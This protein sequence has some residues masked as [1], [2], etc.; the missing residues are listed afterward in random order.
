VAWQLLFPTV[1]RTYIPF[2]LILMASCTSG[3]DD[4][5]DTEVAGQ[6]VY[7]DAATNHDGTAKDAEAPPAQDVHVS[8]VVEGTGTIPN[9]D[10]QCALDPA[11]AFQAVYSGSATLD[12]SGAYVGAMGAA[13]SSI[14][15]PSG[16]EIPELTVSLITDVTVRAELEATTENCQTYCAAE[17]RADA[18]AECGATADQAE[19][20]ANAEATAEASCTTTC[21]TES[22][23]IVAEISVGASAVGELD[24]E[25]LQA[26]A[27]GQLHADLVFDH[28]E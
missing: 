4:G 27:L 11:G 15:T 7:R 23:S 2:V 18:E 8:I 6:A 20:R 1:M 3:G 17:A 14:T 25:A 10:P 22:N 13:T 16:C 28:Q 24:A 19:C 12:D 9:P 21:T 26:A 5:G